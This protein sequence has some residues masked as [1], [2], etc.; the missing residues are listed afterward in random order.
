MRNRETGTGRLI[1]DWK[2]RNGRRNLGLPP[3]SRAAAT[4]GTSREAR[5]N[6]GVMEWKTSDEKSRGNL[7]TPGPYRLADGPS[8]HG[9][10]LQGIVVR[11][12]ASNG[13]ND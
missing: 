3:V 1:G 8:N 10:V 7:G 11:V 4:N 12:V 6:P 9:K 2:T 5:F 13:M